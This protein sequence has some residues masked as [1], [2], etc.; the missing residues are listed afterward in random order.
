[1]THSKSYPDITS[2]L[3]F[4]TEKIKARPIPQ[5]T[6]PNYSGMKVVGIVEDVV[7]L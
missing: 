1:M 4:L 2:Y 7:F 6:V 3:T 5:T